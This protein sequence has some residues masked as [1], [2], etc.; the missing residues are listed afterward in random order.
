M[1]DKSQ[2]KMGVSLNYILTIVSNALG[3]LLISFMTNRLGTSAYGLYETIGAMA[4]YMAVLDF[5]VN[6]TITRYISKFRAQND[7]KSQKNFL[8]TCIILYS[9]LAVIVILIG[10]IIWLNVYKIYP[11]YTSEEI[12]IAKSMF[13]ILI[14]NIS[15]SLPLRSFSAILNGYE[16]FTFPRMMNIFRV[17]LRFV[18]IIIF[19]NLGF[20]IVTVVIIDTIINLSILIINMLYVLGI[21]KVTIHLDK[22]DIKL[23]KEVFVF[24]LPIFLTMI[25]DQIF[26][27]VDHN[28]I[29]MMR[30][31]I[32]AAIC[33]Y[34]MRIALIF[35]NFSTA[36]SEVFLPRVTKMVVNNAS[37]DE[38]T[39]LMIKVGRIQ[40][41]V[42]GMIL[43]GFLLYGQ[44]FFVLWIGR[45]P[46]TKPIISYYVAAIV[47]IPLILP[48]IQNTGISILVAKNKH[49]VRSTVYFIIAVLNIGLTVVLINQFDI[50]GASIATAIALTLGN[51]IIINIYYSKVIGLKI[52]RFFK[53]C[54]F[55]LLI[56]I[57]ISS[58]FG[59]LI[60][61]FIAIQNS[62]WNLILCCVLFAVIYFI[63]MWFI[64]MNKYEKDMVKK[65]VQKVTK[66]GIA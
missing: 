49:R 34:G 60:L 33:A 64:G 7:E 58:G 18:V 15:L 31:T 9:I 43:S 38:L 40:L 45:N 62:W 6:S 46:D 54:V 19:I 14:A 28:I 36:M 26:W 61:R 3:F 13:I 35:I 39:D 47:M 56:P 21:L 10:Y 65:I 23:L 16:K 37:G 22:F 32:A 29:S 41:L 1:N 51:G 30:G 5:G 24:S 20:G 4:G 57:V 53:D 59:Y 50:I 11:K 66:R 52:D 55:K 8:A 12:S 48:L 17:I 2:L 25:Y 63:I 27:K 42:L 44:N